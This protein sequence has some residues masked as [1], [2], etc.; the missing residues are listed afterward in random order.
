MAAAGLMLNVTIAKT[1][2]TSILGTFNE[3]YAWYTI[4]S[5]ITVWGIH[6]SILKLVP[7]QNDRDLKESVLKS[8][9]IGTIVISVVVTLLLETV[10]FMMKMNP[11]AQ[12][13]RIAFIGLIFFSV[14]K[15][16]LNYLNA[17]YE[18]VTFAVF[19]AVRYILL[20]T[21]AVAFA[22]IRV[23][24]NYLAIMFPITEGLT[25]AILFGFI[26]GKNGVRGHFNKKTMLEVISFGTKIL[27]SNMVVEM[28]T[29]VDVVCLGVLIQNTAKI[30]VYSF[31]ILFTEGFYTIYMTIRKIVNPGLSES[32][33]NNQL[34]Y[35]VRRINDIFTKYL[36]PLSLAAYVLIVM[37]YIFVCQFIGDAE[38]LTG[39]LYIAIIC[40]SIVLTAKSIIWGDLLSQT[41]FPLEESKVNT[42]TVIG[43]VFFNIVLISLFETMG[44][45][46]ATAISYSIYAFLMY[47]MIR[48]KTGL[49]I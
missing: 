37:A 3:T 6:M 7:E 5:Q 44:A 4:L 28:N 31:A 16:L 33:A 9:V 23:D 45:A 49:T 48:K 26:F 25:C 30:G 41:G 47:T 34:E 32:K 46:I 2:D 17:I 36:V 15:V 13:M 43:N 20:V 10:L 21:I 14:N 40:L 35:Y 24:G 11:W 12:S 22:I 38:Y 27:P 1:Y 39:T 29:K 42:M 19:Q 8:A 18:L